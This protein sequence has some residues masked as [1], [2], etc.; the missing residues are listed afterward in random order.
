MVEFH[1][2]KKRRG[3][4]GLSKN[5]NN[6]ETP[7]PFWP[8]LEIDEHD[9]AKANNGSINIGD[10]GKSDTVDSSFGFP[11]KEDGNKETKT[12]SST[13]RVEED[14]TIDSNLHPPTNDSKKSSVA[15]TRPEGGVISFRSRKRR[16]KPSANPNDTNNNDIPQLCGD[17]STENTLTETVGDADGLVKKCA[18]PIDT[19]EGTSATQGT[20]TFEEIST[21][22]HE[23][24]KQTANATTASKESTD[25]PLRN[26]NHSKSNTDD[27]S[28]VSSNETRTS[29]STPRAR[30]KFLLQKK[31]PELDKVASSIRDI[32]FRM[33]SPSPALLQNKSSP[34]ACTRGSNHSSKNASQDKETDRYNA[35]D[36]EQRKPPQEEA[37]SKLQDICKRQEVLLD[38]IAEMELTASKREKELREQTQVQKDTLQKQQ[39]QYQQQKDLTAKL[40]RDY[41]ILQ[42]ANESLKVNLDAHRLELVAKDEFI[43]EL[44]DSRRSIQTRFQSRI[45]EQF[46]VI[47]KHT[48]LLAIERVEN[49]KLRN[50]IILLEKGVLRSAEEKDNHGVD[51]GAHGSTF[52]KGESPVS[53]RSGKE[54]HAY[55]NRKRHRQNNEQQQNSAPDRGGSTVPSTTSSAYNRR[56]RRIAWESD[57]S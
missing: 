21:N 18:Q 6:P 4:A 55:S 35:V 52:Y 9:I 8:G 56:I 7:T 37:F 50:R 17:K 13:G 32:L 36:L 53:R 43:E 40:Q 27:L 15:T 54:H 49:E 24:A 33:I 5:I 3:I 42:E 38:R 25:N 57:G 39:N 51:M 12:D 30:I 41:Q 2:P 46:R 29:G 48:N 28:S 19:T 10:N 44:E 11:A 16:R 47:E 20:A 22:D 45:D 1:V 26:S 31:L 14:N 34:S 23:T